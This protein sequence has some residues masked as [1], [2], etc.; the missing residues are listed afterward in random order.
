MKYLNSNLH[1]LIIFTS[2]LI[3]SPIIFLHT[4]QCMI[5]NIQCYYKINLGIGEPLASTTNINVNQILNIGNSKN[6]LESFEKNIRM[7]IT[8][9]RYKIQKQYNVSSFTLHFFS[10]RDFSRFGSSVSQRRQRHSSFIEIP[11]NM[12][13]ELAFSNYG[14]FP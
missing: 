4:S 8:V 10:Q 2:P 9:T 13:I 14:P 6:M 3:L 7:S 12:S 5:F 1:S 11:Q